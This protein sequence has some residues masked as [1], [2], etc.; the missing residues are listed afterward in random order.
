MGV[1]LLAPWAPPSHRARVDHT[2]FQYPMSVE[3]GVPLHAHLLR[4]HRG[5]HVTRIVGPY[6]VVASHSHYQC[7]VAPPIRDASASPWPL[8]ASGERKGTLNNF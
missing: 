5:A 4:H 3:R 8:P 1:N 7:R 6:A 2:I